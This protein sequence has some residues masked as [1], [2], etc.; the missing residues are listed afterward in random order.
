MAGIINNQQIV[1]TDP[2]QLLGKSFIDPFLS[3]ARVL[4]INSLVLGNAASPEKVN[5]L[6]I[7]AFFH[8]KRAE[9]LAMFPMQNADRENPG[10]S[11]I[12]AEFLLLGSRRSPVRAGKIKSE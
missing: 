1:R 8:R 2:F 5:Q 11:G 3:S 9:H 4:Q 6:R 7:A 12:P 10:M